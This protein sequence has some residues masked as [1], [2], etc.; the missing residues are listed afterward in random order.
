MTSFPENSVTDLASMDTHVLM[1]LFDVD[2]QLNFTCHF[3]VTVA[4]YIRF[5]VSELVPFTV[6]RFTEPFIALGALVGPLAWK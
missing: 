3:L 4:T 5:L 2:A 1:F 6:V